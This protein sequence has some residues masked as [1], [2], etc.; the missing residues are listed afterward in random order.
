MTLILK[1]FCQQQKDSSIN[2][3]IIQGLGWKQDDGASLLTDVKLRLS[4][5]RLKD[6]FQIIVDDSF[7]SDEPGNSKAY[8]DAVK[9]SEP[10]T[11]I[12]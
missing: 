8:S 11:A 9:D 12:R 3:K 10:D 7:E 5:P 2:G 6:R 1:Y 4:L